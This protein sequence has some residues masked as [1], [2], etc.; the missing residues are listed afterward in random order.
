MTFAKFGCLNYNYFKIQIP[1]KREIIRLKYFRECEFTVVENIDSCWSLW[2]FSGGVALRRH[3]S[4]HAYD[5]IPHFKRNLMDI[6]LD[7]W[8][9]A[10]T[11]T[12]YMSTL[13]TT[14]QPLHTSTS[15]WSWL[16]Q[17]YFVTCR[18]ISDFTIFTFQEW[19]MFDQ[20][21]QFRGASE[22]NRSVRPERQFRRT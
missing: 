22:P 11:E 1:Y 14:A 18:M 5:S 19:P 3:E 7:I 21:L 13:Q 20:I 4:K 17:N 8:T 2:M 9:S 6:Y 15:T 12:C 16:I 10:E